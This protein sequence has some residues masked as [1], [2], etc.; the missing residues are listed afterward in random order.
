MNPGHKAKFGVEEPDWPAQSPYLN[1]FQ[2]VWG[3]LE[4]AQWTRP[5]LSSSPRRVEAVIAAKVKGK[6]M[7]NMWKASVPTLCGRAWL[8]V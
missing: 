7:L 1:L 8:A 3:E 6:T 5:S 2:Q 4:Q